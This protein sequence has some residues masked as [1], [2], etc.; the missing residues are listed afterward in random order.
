MQLHCLERVE[1][2]DDDD[3]ADDV[4]ADVDV[5]VDDNNDDDDDKASYGSAFVGP[6]PNMAGAYK[7]G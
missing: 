3:E 4:D 1:D 5:D 7:E 2:N 6:H